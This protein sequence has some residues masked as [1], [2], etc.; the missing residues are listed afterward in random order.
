MTI[1]S[2]L[3]QHINERYNF[4]FVQKML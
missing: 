2:Q 4:C 1:P 3:N